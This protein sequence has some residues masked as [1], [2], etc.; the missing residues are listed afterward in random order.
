[1]RK[2]RDAKKTMVYLD[3][4]EH[5]ALKKIAAASGVPMAEQIRQAVADY[6]RRRK[7]VKS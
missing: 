6:L 5:A 3:A 2:M 1:M 4:P 7:A